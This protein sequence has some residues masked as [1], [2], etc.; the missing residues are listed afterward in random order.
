[1][2]VHSVPVFQGFV[3]LLEKISS[4]ALN[5]EAGIFVFAMMVAATDR[6]NRSVDPIVCCKRVPR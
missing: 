4:L 1:M 3:S 5:L 6:E 2:C